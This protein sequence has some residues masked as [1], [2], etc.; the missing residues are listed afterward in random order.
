ML[1]RKEGKNGERKN[2]VTKIRELITIFLLNFFHM[3]T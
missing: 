2:I 1:R 3:Y